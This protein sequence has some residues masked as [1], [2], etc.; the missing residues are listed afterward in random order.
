M[1]L[2]PDEQ[3]VIAGQSEANRLWIIMK[4][5]TQVLSR[6]TRNEAF[7]EDRADTILNKT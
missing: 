3:S 6:L 7:D 1:F 2:K 5:V 4:F